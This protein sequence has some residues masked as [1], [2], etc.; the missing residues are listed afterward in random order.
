MSSFKSAVR[1][2]VDIPQF[3]LTMIATSQRPG[4]KADYCINVYLWLDLPNDNFVCK[5]S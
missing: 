1:A 4:P 5:V 3:I 2:H